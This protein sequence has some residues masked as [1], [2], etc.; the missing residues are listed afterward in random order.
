MSYIDD[1]REYWHS[2]T[3]SGHRDDS[4]LFYRRK[5]AEHAAILTDDDRTAGAV[6]LGTGAGELLKHLLELVNVEVAIDFSDNMLTEARHRLGEARVELRNADAFTYLAEARHAVW[7]ASASLNQYLGAGDH[8]KLLEIFQQNRSARSIYY[9]D[10]ID[11]IRYVLWRHGIL[12]RYRL[13]HHRSSWAKRLAKI[14]LG[15]FRMLANAVRCTGAPSDVRIGQSGF[16][17][18]PNFW[19]QL[20]KANGL[21]CELTSSRY[22]EYRYHVVIQKRCPIGLFAPDA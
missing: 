21:N 10:T 12:G 13:S 6:D 2:R 4:D 17:F 8:R 16:A 9:F 11:P 14:A 5:A 1:F 18:H 19:L 20:S 22:Y 3:R 15:S 7:I